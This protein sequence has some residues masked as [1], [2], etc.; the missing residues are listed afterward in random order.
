MESLFG[1]KTAFE[2]LL[3][4]LEF[5]TGYATEIS[6]KL[7]C[8]LNMVQKQLEKFH[9]AGIL[10][11][12]RSERNKVYG[13]NTHHLLYSALQKFLKTI[14]ILKKKN[15][16]KTSD[17]PANG[18]Y[19]SLEKRLSTSESLFR[20]ADALNPFPSPKPFVKTFS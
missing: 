11:V 8:P 4:L 13:W 12:S 14:L 3:Y 20:E 7:N 5:K 6:K 16:F 9:A 19:L 2:L 1:S 10:R 17:S 18:R 15:S